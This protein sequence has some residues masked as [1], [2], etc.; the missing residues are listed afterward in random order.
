MLT[1]WRAGSVPF[2]NNLR[3][4][5]HSVP[6]VNYL[7]HAFREDWLIDCFSFLHILGSQWTNWR[8]CILIVELRLAPLLSNLSKFDFSVFFWHLALLWSWSPCSMLAVNPNYFQSSTQASEYIPT[9]L[10]TSSTP[11]TTTMPTNTIVVFIFT[12]SPCITTIHPY[13][14][15]PAKLHHSIPL[16]ILPIFVLLLPPF[17]NWLLIENFWPRQYLQS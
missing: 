12:P 10:A 2:L 8:F 13:Y 16:P 14:C 17:T 9:S 5:G 7:V 15:P 1:G 3:D 11:T 6:L 4:H